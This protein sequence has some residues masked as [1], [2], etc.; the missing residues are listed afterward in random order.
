MACDQGH[1]ETAVALMEKG[2]DIHMKDN[3]S[4]SN[5]CYLDT[6]YIYFTCNIWI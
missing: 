4:I 6:L 2:S 3:V 5:T 1:K